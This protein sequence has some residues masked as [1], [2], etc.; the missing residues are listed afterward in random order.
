LQAGGLSVREI[1]PGVDLQRDVLD[2][3]DFALTVDPQLKLMDAALYREAPL[4]MKLREHAH[5]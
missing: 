1:A 3:A 4:G 5:A 2:Q